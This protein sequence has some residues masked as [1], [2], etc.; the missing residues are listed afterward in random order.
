MMKLLVGVSVWGAYLW[1]RV[2]CDDPAGVTGNGSGD[3]YGE[4]AF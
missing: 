3:E 2:R 4:G 1:V